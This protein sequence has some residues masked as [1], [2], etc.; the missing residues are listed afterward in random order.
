MILKAGCNANATYG[1]PHKLRFG[2]LMQMYLDTSKDERGNDYTCIGESVC[3]LA[4]TFTHVAAGEVDCRPASPPHR[5]PA[6]LLRRV[7]PREEP[8]G[9]NTGV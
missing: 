1:A 9:A 8:G 4:S 3:L 2:L 7:Q 6:R 5:A